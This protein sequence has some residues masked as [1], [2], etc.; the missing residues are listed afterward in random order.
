M[1]QIPLRLCGWSLRYQAF[2]STFSEWKRNLR[3]SFGK[4]NIPRVTVLTE[5]TAYLGSQPEKQPPTRKACSRE[6]SLP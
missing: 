4:T 2:L 5:A 3:T 6:L 1:V